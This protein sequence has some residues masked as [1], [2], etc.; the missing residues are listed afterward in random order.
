MEVGEYVRTKT[1]IAKVIGKDDD[2][3]IMLDNQQIVTKTEAKSI[4]HSKNIIKLIEKGDYVNG[5]KV[6]SIVTNYDNTED[7][8][9]KLLGYDNLL[10]FSNNDIKSIVTKEQFKQVQY[11]V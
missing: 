2:N 10:Y 1:N 3:N 5:W 11:E 7:I 9:F 8:G 4:K 6:L